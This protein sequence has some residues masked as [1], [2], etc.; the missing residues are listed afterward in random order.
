MLKIIFELLKKLQNTLQ[1]NCVILIVEIEIWFY[2]TTF[3]RFKYS[4]EYS[5]LRCFCSVN[6]VNILFNEHSMSWIFYAMDF[7]Y[8]LWKFY[9]TNFLFSDFFML[10]NSMPKIQPYFREQHTFL[11]FWKKLFFYCMFVVW[12]LCVCMDH[13]LA[14]SDSCMYEIQQFVAAMLSDL[15]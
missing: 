12:R 5:L 6:A 10:W 3:L 15:W 9:A 2:D 4:Y 13:K 11:I 7:L 1:N 8:C 14:R